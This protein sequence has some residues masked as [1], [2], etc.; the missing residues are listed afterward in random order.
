MCLICE[1]FLKIYGM[2]LKLDKRH[3]AT[4]HSKEISQ[5]LLHP[6]MAVRYRKAIGNLTASL[7]NQEHR[8]EAHIHLR[9]LIE[10]I[11]LT[12]NLDQ[13]DL[14]I[15]LY[16]D[17]AGILQIASKDNSMNTIGIK[18]RLRQIAAND[19]HLSEPSVELVAGAGCQRYLPL[20]IGRAHV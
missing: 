14:S 15:D 7:N 10:K 6:T 11:V 19:N 20:Q 17:L 4:L 8:S 1:L 5:P 9:S 12:P 18:K 13:N 3:K 2:L 16:G